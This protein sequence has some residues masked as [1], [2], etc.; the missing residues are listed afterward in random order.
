MS[1]LM[2][3]TLLSVGGIP[4]LFL[5]KFKITNFLELR[6]FLNAFLARGKK[7]GLVFLFK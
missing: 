6:M 4:T 1:I 2:S 3:S 7:T 5:N